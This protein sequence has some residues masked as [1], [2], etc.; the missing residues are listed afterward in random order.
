V[1]SALTLADY[2]GD[3]RRAKC[4]SCGRVTTADMLTLVTKVKVAK[5]SLLELAGVRLRGNSICDGCRERIF[6]AGI[7][8]GVLYQ[9]LDGQ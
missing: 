7:D 9:V 6:R 3:N 8:R 2:Y 1:A 5:R 4:P